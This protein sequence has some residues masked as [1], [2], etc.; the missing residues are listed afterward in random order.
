MRPLFVVF[1]V[2]FFAVFFVVLLLKIFLP[3]AVRE[4]CIFLPILKAFIFPLRVVHE[5]IGTCT[6]MVRRCDARQ[7]SA[8]ER[9]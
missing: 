9:M 6:G 4:A 5:D 3:I 2:V 7:R 8:R 1:F